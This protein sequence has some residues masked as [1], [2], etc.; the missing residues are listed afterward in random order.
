MSSL[1]NKLWCSDP[2]ADSDLSWRHPYRVPYRGT[3][4]DLTPAAPLL[5]SIPLA[6]QPAPHLAKPGWHLPAAF[7]G[8]AA[9]PNHSALVVSSLAQV[10]LASWNNWCPGLTSRM[11]NHLSLLCDS[12]QVILTSGAFVSF[13][14][15]SWHLQLWGFCAQTVPNTRLNSV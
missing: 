8:T 15:S 9:Q 12:A 5:G 2:Q 1:P 14:L 7:P 6:L 10:I 11:L 3:S 13:L 4:S